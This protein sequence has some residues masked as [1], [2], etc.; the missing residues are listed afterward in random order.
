MTARLRRLPAVLVLLTAVACAT[1]PATGRRQFSLVSEGQE[2]ELGREASEQV[3]AMLGL[4]EDQG[5]QSYVNSIGQ[6]LAANSERPKLDWSFQVVDDAAVNAF[7]LPGGYIYVTRGLLAHVNSEAELAAVLGHEIAHVTARHSANQITKAQLASIGLGVGM[8][9]KPELQRFGQVGELGLGLLLLKHGRDAENQADELGI[10]YMTRADYPASEMPEVLQM[11]QRVGE[12]ENAGRVPNWLS[13]H[14]SPQDRVRR[15]SEKISQTRDAGGG[16]IRREAYLR[17]IDGIVFGPDPREGFFKGST[18]YHPDMAFQ[19]EFPRGFQGQNQK[20]AVGAISPN[21]DAVVVV[22]LTGR[23]S[24]ESASREFFSQQGIQMGRQYRGD[25]GGM[26]AV[27][28]EFAAASSQTPVRGLAAFVEHGGRV[29][30][31]LGYTTSAGWSRYDDTLEEAVSSFQRL[32]DRKYLDAE[33]MR[34]KIVPS[35]RLSDVDDLAR[36]SPVGRDTLLLINGAGRDEPVRGAAFM[37]TVVGNDLAME[38]MQD[39]REQRR[40]TSER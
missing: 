39:Q 40:R 26:D 21:Q 5:L 33:P 36:R 4:Y 14:P 30:Q 15:V 19:I 12:A 25:I 28:H 16:S 1:N 35:S 34:L 32:R 38:I 6:R 22:T 20:Q 2:I 29:F 11:L 8:I 24:P 23:G 13:T 37:K 3:R 10:R 9:L 18:F 31:I 7:A 17:Q 27:T